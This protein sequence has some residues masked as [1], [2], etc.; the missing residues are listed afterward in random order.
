MGR[1]VTL[2]P[3]ARC[4]VA[5]GDERLG[6]DHRD[7]AGVDH[8]ES[9]SVGRDARRRVEPRALDLEQGVLP[10]KLIALAGELLDVVAGHRQRGRLA[11]IEHRQ[12]ERQGDRGDRE[13]EDPEIPR[14][15]AHDRRG[16]ERD[17]ARACLAP[18]PNVAGEDARYAA[19]RGTH[20][21]HGGGAPR[22]PGGRRNKPDRLRGDHDPSFS[23]T[24][25]LA[26]RARGWRIVSSAAAING[27]RETTRKPARC[28]QTQ[29]GRWGG[30]MQSRDSR[31]MYCFTARSSSERKAMTASRPP[32][33]RVLIAASRPLARFASSSFPAT[34]SAWKTRVA[35]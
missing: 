18:Q 27:R 24:R 4:E 34:R 2:P 15:G 30:Q 19:R 6:G 13:P 9:L 17:R 16:P 3:R 35:G 32:R 1:T 26:L 21:A 25:S 5:L 7:V 22:T 10:A 23:A 11:D 31:A 20:G 29:V 8:P 33:R 28:P 12:A 14:G